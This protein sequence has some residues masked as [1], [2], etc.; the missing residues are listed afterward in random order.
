MAQ[1]EL[2][3]RRVRRLG[4]AGG[5]PNAWYYRMPWVLAAAAVMVLLIYLMSLFE[6]VTFLCRHLVEASRERLA[7]R[8]R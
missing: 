8:R 4:I 2:I 3:K 1:I 5:N 6:V 7:A